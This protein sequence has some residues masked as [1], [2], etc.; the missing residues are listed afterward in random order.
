MNNPEKK[1]ETKDIL[2]DLKK[3]N[4]LTNEKIADYVG[5]SE[6]AVSNWMNGQ[7]PRNENIEKLAK[8]FDVDVRTRHKLTRL[9][10]RSDNIVPFPKPITFLHVD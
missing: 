6:T 5:V 10:V 2:S 9:F 4:N 8:L 3:L 1:K 7:M